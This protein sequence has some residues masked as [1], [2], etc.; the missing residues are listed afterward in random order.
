M[1]IKK[2]PKRL[3]LFDILHNKIGILHLVKTFGMDI[4]EDADGKEF[5]KI[6]DKWVAREGFETNYYFA[7]ELRKGL[8]K[9]LCKT[10]KV[11]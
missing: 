10:Q 7:E 6:F 2:L 8:N 11:I 4:P 5:R 3:S 1:L 9:Y